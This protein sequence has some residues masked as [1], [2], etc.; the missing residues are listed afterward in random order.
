MNSPPR[1]TGPDPVGIPAAVPRKIVA[2]ATFVLP[3]GASRERY[4]LEFLADL[5]WMN[6]RGQARY[7][8]GV[9]TRAWA[10]RTALDKQVS[11]P[12]PEEAMKLQSP[13]IC[14]L[15]G[16]HKWDLSTTDSGLQGTCIR[17]GKVATLGGSGIPPGRFEP[18]ISGPG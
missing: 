6:R 3:R 4:R 18:Q 15:R 16:H 2:V 8:I 7:A 12:L 14:R 1:D 11:T 9:L 17:C 5:Y 10:L 13:W